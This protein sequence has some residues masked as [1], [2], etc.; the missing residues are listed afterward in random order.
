VADRDRRTLIACSAGADS[1]ALAIALASATS[2]LVIGHVV[3]DLRP[4]DVALADRDAARELSAGLGIAFVEDVVEVASL[5]G[6]A[7][8][9][10]RRARYRSL[11]ALAAKTGCPFVASA[12]SADDELE[13]VLMGLV[14]GAGPRGMA[15]IARSRPVGDAT[16]IRP[17]AGSS[18]ADSEAVCSL[19]GWVWREDQ[20]NLDTTRLRAAIRHEVA[21][22]LAA[23][24]PG[25]ASRV[26]RSAALLR[27]AAGLIDDRVSELWER[28]DESD[29]TVLWERSIVGKERKI[30]IG[31]LLRRAIVHL[32]GERRLDRMGWQALSGCIDAACDDE[33]QQRRFELSGASV[34]VD[35]RRIQVTRDSST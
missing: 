17:M 25:V 19:A 34:S 11:A 23:L 21:P 1:S 15:G 18:R 10:A 24:R 29:G 12:H 20:T 16:L 32:N 4:R 26:S 27:D 14:R 13:T 33:S 22:L 6:N 30:V 9:N 5:R 8:A 3:H 35:A 2:E 7:E 31:A 28:R